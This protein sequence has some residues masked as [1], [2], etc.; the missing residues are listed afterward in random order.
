MPALHAK[1]ASVDAES[2][3]RI[4]QNDPQRLLR[5]LEVFEITG[6]PL[7]SLRNQRS[8]PDKFDF[9]NIGLFPQNRSLLHTR[10][11]QRFH[12]ML[13]NGFESEVK[14]LLSDNRMSAAAPAMRCVGYRQML[15]Y[16]DGTVSYDEMVLRGIAA[17]RQLAK[18]QLTWMRKMSD[19]QRFDITIDVETLLS[20]EC[21]ALWAAR[22]RL[23]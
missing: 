20:S 18:R 8:A 21:V 7:S 23:W 2:A 6:V 1:L 9:L 3:G 16:L 11:E 4:N 12:E 22:H 13:D 19:L 14:N 15:T 10:I 5:A 17:T